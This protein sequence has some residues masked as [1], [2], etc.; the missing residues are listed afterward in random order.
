MKC[1]S[2]NYTA[3]R[4]SVWQKTDDR[5]VMTKPPHT[6]GTFSKIFQERW[7]R[8]VGGI[9]YP[10]HP[11]VIHSMDLHLYTPLLIFQGISA[12]KCGFRRKRSGNVAWP[13]LCYCIFFIVCEAEKVLGYAWKRTVPSWSIHETNPFSTA[14]GVE[15][16]ETWLLPPHMWIS[17]WFFTFILMF[18]TFFFTITLLYTLSS[19]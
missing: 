1:Q 17:D 2:I 5:Y 8:L 10:I 3:L 16:W 9:I 6:P 15:G 7:K 12:S 4:Y 14:R 13:C 11:D 19:N 18:F